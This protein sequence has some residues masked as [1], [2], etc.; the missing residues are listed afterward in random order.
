MTRLPLLETVFCGSYP[1]P[2]VHSGFQEG[3]WRSL[4]EHRTIMKRSKEMCMRGPTKWGCVNEWCLALLVVAGRETSASSESD[5][6]NRTVRDSVRCSTHLAHA[7]RLCS[8]AKSGLK[9]H[10]GTSRA[11]GSS[12]RRQST[13]RSASRC[14]F[15]HLLPCFVL[16][17]PGLKSLAAQSL[18]RG[19]PFKEGIQAP[20]RT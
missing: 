9:F 14:K 6:G 10:G 17:Q 7:R 4:T 20:F 1:F 12:Q 3:W 19:V 11:P 2:L 16:W 15:S 13:S 8:L 5:A 18:M